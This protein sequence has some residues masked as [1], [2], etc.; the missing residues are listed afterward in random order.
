M[1][2]KQILSER[3]KLSI[4]STR[5]YIGD[6]EILSS[7]PQ[8][9]GPFLSNCIKKVSHSSYDVAQLTI[10]T[11]KASNFDYHCVSSYLSRI[12]AETTASSAGILDRTIRILDGW[13]SDCY[14]KYI[15]LS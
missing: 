3:E 4:A 5:T 1:P 2:L 10:D 13:S 6:Q 12:G 7:E 14:R 11:L 15:G 8:G 9:Q